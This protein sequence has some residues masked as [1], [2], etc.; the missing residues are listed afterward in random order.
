MIPVICF[1]YWVQCSEP[2]CCLSRWLWCPWRPEISNPL[3]VHFKCFFLGFIDVGLWGC[4]EPAIM[5]LKEFLLCPI[6]HVTRDLTCHIW[7]VYCRKTAEAEKSIDVISGWFCPKQSS[8]ST[9]RHVYMGKVEAVTDWPT[10]SNRKEVQ[11]FLGFANFY[12]RFIRNFSSV[13]APMHVLTSP[14]IRLQWNPTADAAFQ[15][16]KR[17]FTTAPVL[18]LPDSRQQFV[19][20]VDASDMGIGAILSQRST[21]DNKLHPCAFLSGKLSPAERNYDIGDR[22]LLAT[23]RTTSWVNVPEE[24]EDRRNITSSLSDREPSSCTLNKHS[25]TCCEPAWQTWHI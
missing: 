7:D 16:L 19:V 2:I 25:K 6:V 11:R 17:A 10:P 23:S 1:G 4:T 24:L 21:N 8:H 22:E 13:A 14:A 3:K 12:R 9:P 15:R 5:G 18:T 20:E